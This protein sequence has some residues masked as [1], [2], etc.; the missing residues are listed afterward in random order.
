MFP[1]P[2]VMVCNDHDMHFFVWT[3]D[4]DAKHGA[5]R[6]Q[7]QRRSILPSFHCLQF[8]FGWQ[9]APVKPIEPNRLLISS[10]ATAQLLLW[11]GFK[12]RGDLSMYERDL[13]HF[14]EGNELNSAQRWFENVVMPVVTG[15]PPQFGSVQRYSINRER[16]RN[17][18][19]W[20]RLIQ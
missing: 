4:I 5:Y 11:H 13:R 17:G 19:F 16:T 14:F 15:D 8:D 1:K 9:D 3:K 6:A 2:F 7:R 10:K 18:D 12:E 20:K